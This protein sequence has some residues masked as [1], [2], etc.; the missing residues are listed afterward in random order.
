MGNGF[1]ARGRSTSPATAT[2]RRSK[3]GKR[4]RPLPL[5]R[6]PTAPRPLTRPL[7]FAER[8]LLSLF[9]EEQ[10]QVRSS[11]SGPTNRLFVYSNEKAVMTGGLDKSFKLY[12]E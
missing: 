10:S 4:V 7:F 6:L 2:R 3:E 8:E 11:A 12:R 5:G 9:F 1:A